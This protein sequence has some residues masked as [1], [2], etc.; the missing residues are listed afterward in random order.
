MDSEGQVLLKKSVKKSYFTFCV[1]TTSVVCLEILGFY[2]LFQSMTPVPDRKHHWC[3]WVD[4]QVY[5]ITIDNSNTNV[6][7]DIFE[8]QYEKIIGIIDN[9]CDDIFNNETVYWCIPYDNNIY[10]ANLT[11]STIT[12]SSLILLIKYMIVMLVGSGYAIY[13]FWCAIPYWRHPERGDPCLGGNPNNTNLNPR[14]VGNLSPAVPT[15]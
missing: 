13:V 9:N 1:I 15:Q 6:C 12:D 4:K 2:T 8:Y 7:T 10:Y 5:N 3:K 11:P 14:V